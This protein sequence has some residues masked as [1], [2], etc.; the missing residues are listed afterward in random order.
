MSILFCQR[1]PQRQDILEP[2][3]LL[4]IPFTQPQPGPAGGRCQDVPE[5]P[6]I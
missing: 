2:A 3:R 5:L 6:G 4:S 1:A